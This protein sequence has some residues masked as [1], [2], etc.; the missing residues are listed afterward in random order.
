MDYQ[1]EYC[2]NGNFANIH[3]TEQITDSYYVGG[4]AN[5]DYRDQELVG[6]L[7]DTRGVVGVRLEKYRIGIEC[8]LA[9]SV[10]EV[11]TAA[12]ETVFIWMKMRGLIGDDEPVNQL[13]TLRHDLA[14]TKCPKCEERER[15]VLD[16]DGELEALKA[17]LAHAK[18]LLE[19]FAEQIAEAIEVRG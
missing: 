7:N 9:F 6:L 11:L 17:E 16:S 8:G 13:P 1:F 14:A 3:L 18:R 19:E 15:S 2:P 12:M 4:C 5:G 10:S